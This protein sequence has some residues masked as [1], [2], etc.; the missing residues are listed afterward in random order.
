[1][2]YNYAKIVLITLFWG[3]HQCDASLASGIGHMLVEAEVCDN[4]AVAEVYADAQQDQF[5]KL[6]RYGDG[7]AGDN[8]LMSEGEVQSSVD[9]KKKVAQTGKMKDEPSDAASVGQLVRFD[10]TDVIYTRDIVLLWDLMDKRW[11]CE[12]FFEG[13]KKVSIKFE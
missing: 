10:S 2:L 5:D 9:V 4:L 7:Q 6:Q 11:C 3:M 1:M 12:T 13:S 8:P